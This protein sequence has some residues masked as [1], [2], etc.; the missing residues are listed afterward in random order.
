M[1]V[2][3]RVEVDES[4]DDSWKFESTESA[5]PSSTSIFG[6]VVNMSVVDP[7]AP[8]L[9][10]AGPSS[11]MQ[12]DLKGFDVTAAYR[13]ALDN[14]QVSLA[15]DALSRL[16]HTHFSTVALYHGGV[17]WD[18]NVSDDQVPHP[19][20]AILALVELMEASTGKISRLHLARQ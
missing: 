7:S 9:D 1:L 15:V 20:A 16:F 4:C 5:F 3:D 10:T 18:E 8:K 19:I 14:E 2:E 17:S 11:R 12:V 6:F 13:R